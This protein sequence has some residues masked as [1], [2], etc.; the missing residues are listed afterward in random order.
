MEARA[1]REIWGHGQLAAREFS[2]VHLSVVSSLSYLSHAHY[3]HA[4]PARPRHSVNL[5]CRQW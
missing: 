2:A 5:S 4:R 3:D 1:V